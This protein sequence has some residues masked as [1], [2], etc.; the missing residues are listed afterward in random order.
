MQM[1]SHMA[2]DAVDFS[3]YHLQVSNPDSNG[4]ANDFTVTDRHGNNTRGR[5]GF[6][7]DAAMP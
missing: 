2:F 5:L 1:A 7:R 3:G 4:V 6:T